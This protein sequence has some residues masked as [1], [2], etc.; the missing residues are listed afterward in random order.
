MQEMSKN[1]AMRLQDFS[2]EKMTEETLKI[3][4]NIT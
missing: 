3:I 4:E 2:E 1:A